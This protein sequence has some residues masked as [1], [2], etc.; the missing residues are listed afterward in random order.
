MLGNQLILALHKLVRQLRNSIINGVQGLTKCGVPNLRT[1]SLLRR[2]AAPLQDD[3]GFLHRGIALRPL[4]GIG[5]SFGGG[6]GSGRTFLLAAGMSYRGHRGGRG[7]PNR[8]GGRGRGRPPPGLSG[9]E[10]GMFYKQKSQQKRQ[11]RERQ[12]V[13]WHLSSALLLS[14]SVVIVCLTNPNALGLA[15]SVCLSVCLSL[16]LC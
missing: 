5:A 11:E 15:C 2:R 8:G 12:E 16:S 3:P 13:C 10:I 9:R 14:C 1:S 6:V 4:T 7:G